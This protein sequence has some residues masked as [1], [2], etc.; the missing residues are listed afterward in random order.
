MKDIPIIPGRGL[1]SKLSIQLRLEFLESKKTKYQL[2]IN[3]IILDRLLYSFY[4]TTPL[5]AK[6]L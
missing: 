1:N 5:L 4:P 3:A 6:Q 2:S